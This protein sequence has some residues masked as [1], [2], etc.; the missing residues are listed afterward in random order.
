[1]ADFKSQSDGAR[2]RMSTLMAER[3][4]SAARVVREMGNARAAKVARGTLLHDIATK[5]VKQIR[6]RRG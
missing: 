1:M 2:E 3:N 4:S 6:G 5:G